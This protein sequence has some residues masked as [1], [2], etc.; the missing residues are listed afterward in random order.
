MHSSSRI[1]EN[2]LRMTDDLVRQDFL[3]SPSLAGL[4]FFRDLPLVIRIIDMH[5]IWKRFCLFKKSE[6]VLLFEMLIVG[7]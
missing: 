5:R 6:R 1:Q 7:V 3:I 4:I 2:P